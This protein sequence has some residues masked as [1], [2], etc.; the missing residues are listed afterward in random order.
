MYDVAFWPDIKFFY[1][2]FSRIG[3]FYIGIHFLH[4]ILKENNKI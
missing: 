2:L 4:C 3:L 1:I